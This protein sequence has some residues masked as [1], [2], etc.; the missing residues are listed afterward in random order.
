MMKNWAG[1][2]D[3]SKMI[4]RGDGNPI[5]TFPVRKVA[6]PVDTAFVRSNRTV[7]PDDKV[8]DAMRFE[9][10]DK[11]ALFKSDLAILNIIAANKWRRPIYFTMPY[12]GLGF[13]NYLRR[14]GMAYRLVPVENPATNTT[15]TYDLVMDTKKWSYGNAQIHDVYYDEINRSQLL[16]IRTA[17]LNLALDLIGKNKLAEA[18][19]VLG[20]D[21]KMILEENLPYGMTSGNNNHNRI[22]LGLLEAAY[23]CDDTKLATR[24]GASVQKDLLQQ[25]RYYQSLE[26]DKKASLQ[27]ENSTNESLIQLLNEI[28]KNYA[29]TKNGLD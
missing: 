22:S 2:D 29:K 6:V 12:N 18:R 17:D 8:V 24:I 10:P 1:S 27:Y 21:D 14:D 11:N 16:G 25:R 5:N 7:N 4:D 19:N 28:N 23:R 13:G 15:K 3:P 9:L 20:H 26:N